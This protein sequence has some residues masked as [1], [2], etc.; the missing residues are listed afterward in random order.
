MRGRL[1]ARHACGARSCAFA[2]IPGAHPAPPPAT[3]PPS[4]LPAPRLPAEKHSLENKN[5]ATAIICKFFLDA[6]EKK[7]Y[8]WFWQVPG[9]FPG[10]GG[11][12]GVVPAG[13]RCR[14]HAPGLDG[15][16]LSTPGSRLAPSCPAP[17]PPLPVPPRAVPQRQGLQVPPRSA[18][19][20]CA[21]EPDEGAAGAGGG[22]REAGEGVRGGWGGWA[23][24]LAGGTLAAGRLGGLWRGQ[25]GRR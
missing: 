13:R 21:E 8:G 23:V 6:V 4:S 25:R 2:C 20:V 10:R 19:R 12:R 5:R 3:P 1:V 9:S 17:P 7:Q 14:M 11:A 24:G 18:A 16:Q 15:R 22:Q